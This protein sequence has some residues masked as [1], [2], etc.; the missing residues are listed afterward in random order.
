MHR[1]VLAVPRLARGSHATPRLNA[2]AR[3][4]TENALYW[5]KGEVDPMPP[6]A[7]EQEAMA[8]AERHRRKLRRLERLKGS[9]KARRKRQITNVQPEPSSSLLDRVLSQVRPER[10]DATNSEF[11]AYR[12]EVRA[13]MTD[14]AP[15]YLSPNELAELDIPHVDPDFN[16]EM[17]RP[18]ERPSA[19][20]QRA[21]RSPAQLYQRLL[22]LTNG[23]LH[24][25]HPRPPPSIQTLVEYHDRY[26]ALNSTK[27]YNVLMEYAIRHTD[28]GAAYRLIT[29]MRKHA[30][31]ALPNLETEVLTVRLLV[32]VGRW[33]E[34]WARCWHEGGATYRWAR[35]HPFPFWLE[36]FAFV[37]PAIP[38]GRAR[39]FKVDRDR[40]VESAQLRKLL[41][42]IPRLTGL[43]FDHAPPRLIAALV[44]RLLTADRRDTALDI[45]RGF[46]RGLP[47][48]LHAET[49]RDAVR[50]IDLFASF[51]YESKLPWA[52]VRDTFNELMKLHPDLRPG[53]A[54][55]APVIRTLRYEQNGGRRALAFLKA[56]RARWGTRVEDAT[57]RR[58]I[59]KMAFHND[60]RDIV[61][62]MFKG[63][64]HY[65]MYRRANNP[66]AVAGILGVDDEP[67]ARNR[68]RERRMPVPI[69]QNASKEGAEN[70]LWVSLARDIEKRWGQ[71]WYEDELRRDGMLKRGALEEARNSM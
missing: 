18:T 59:A 57:V 12:A 64:D 58:V 15:V 61:Y 69:L 70:T 65:K 8:A 25:T 42:H 66:A 50:I 45:A 52:K 35:T 5:S 60:R 29:R 34:A 21:P 14:D 22:D 17:A 54:S 51:G 26:S 24:R 3:D 2:R 62:A 71:S 53:P 32:R 56:A 13:G 43:D 16:P 9:S 39:F 28:F 41:E 46:L 36:F 68:G 7:S 38:W 48:T 63:Q 37:S 44:F 33:D 23:L 1:H 40:S 55:I 27:S 11:K 10:R 67:D 31:Q 19:K 47:P 4:I 49:N 30:A 20:V 6:N